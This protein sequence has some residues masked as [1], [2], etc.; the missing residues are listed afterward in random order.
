MAN[1]G[2]TN[3]AI[4]LIQKW[5]GMLILFL[6]IAALNLT[7]GFSGTKSPIY[8]YAVASWLVLLIGTELEKKCKL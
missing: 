3:K 4:L 5:G 2:D 6:T 7:G 1:Q 8:G